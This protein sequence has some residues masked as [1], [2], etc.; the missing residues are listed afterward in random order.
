MG[1]VF[2]P[3]PCGGLI[4]PQPYN[5]Y[6]NWV[7]TD[8]N[9]RDDYYQI[10]LLKGITPLYNQKI[11]VSE[12]IDGS[13]GAEVD[14]LTNSGSNNATLLSNM[15]QKNVWSS[16][17][18]TFYK[19][20]AGNERILF[21]SA[22]IFS[23]PQRRMG[24]GL[25]PES[26]SID[27]RSSTST[28]TN[29]T[30]VKLNEYHGHIIDSSITTSSFAKYS[31]L[32]GYWGFNDELHNRT[33]LNVPVITDG[34]N[35][36]NNG[37]G[38]D[39]TF[40]DGIDTTGARTEPSGRQAQL[41]GSSSYV[42]VD[43]NNNFNFFKDDTYAL[44]MWVTLPVSQSDVSDDYNWLASKNGTYR[45]YTVDNSLNQVLRRRNV[46]TSIY[47]FDLKVYNQ[48]LSTDSGKLVASISDGLNTTS[49]TSSTTVNDSSQHH[50][51]FNKTSTNLELWVDGTMEA[52]SSLSINDQVWNE[53]DMLFGSR[54]LSDGGFDIISSGFNSLSGSI[55]ELRIYNTNLSSTEIG[56][57][58]SNDYQSGS[59]YQT[60][61]VGDAFYKHGIICI[62]DPRPKYK[63]LFMGR[64]GNWNYTFGIAN[65]GFT[66]RYKS[67]K[68][69]QEVSIL[70]E[71][72]ASEFNVSQNPSLRINED[73]NNEQLKGFVTGSDF[74]T[75][76]TTIGLYND[77]GELLAIAKLGSALKN[78]YDTDITVKVRFDL[79]GPFGTPSTMG[80]PPDEPN[81]TLTET[82]P[83]TFIWNNL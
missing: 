56:L 5:V 46:A 53:Y 21:T 37:V 44:S 30:D 71:I 49:I 76:V 72:G 12:S 69:L 20:R 67:T 41:N 79:D 22:S 50:V 13:I 82:S 77:L 7:V 32:I 51:V 9:Y 48:N 58:S 74:R 38:K 68:Q 62:S 66:T 63:N 28:K 24:D 17:N 26:L 47:P 1:N 2:K 60:S 35:F 39:L 25:K 16:I 75:Y 45:E 27:D 70:C 36:N 55:D 61:V 19:H 18:Q 54:Y 14:E 6:K 15:F 29:Y 80:I 40:K 34:S 31:K 81:I 65:Y 10:S 11:N 33:I 23:I 3:I 59:A 43:H 52:S 8:S 57:L 4:R 83:G 64:T 73:I 78:R 42:R